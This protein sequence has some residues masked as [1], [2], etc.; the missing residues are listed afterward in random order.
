M[1]FRSAASTATVSIANSHSANVEADYTPRTQ[2]Q[3]AALP[4]LTPGT[5]L[6]PDVTRRRGAIA[7]NQR[8]PIA[9]DAA[10][11]APTVTSIA[12]STAPA[13]G[14]NVLVRITGT[15]FTAWSEAIVGGALGPYLYTNYVSPTA[16]DIMMDCKRSKVGS[17]TVAVWDHGVQS[18]PQT[19]TLT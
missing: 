9:G 17:S 16:I 1:L 11:A 2:T 15:N 7:P 6:A 10:V 5:I 14:P 13:G 18:A 3:K 12:P 4:N 19:F 8:Y